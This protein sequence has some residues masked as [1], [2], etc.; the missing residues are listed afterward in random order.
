MPLV[1]DAS[2][3]MQIILPEDYLPLLDHQVE[4]R[5]HDPDQLV[6]P[7]LWMYE[8]TSTLAKLTH[9]EQIEREEARHSLRLVLDFPIELVMPSPELTEAAFAWSLRL[10]RANAYDAFYLAL[11]EALGCELWTADR[12]LVNAVGQEWVKNPLD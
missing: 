10:Q 6:A 3:A 8:M 2:L 11:A 1:I 7:S 4:E 5:L 12:R 9:F